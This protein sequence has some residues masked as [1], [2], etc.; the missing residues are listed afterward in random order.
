MGRREWVELDTFLL[1]GRPGPGIVPAGQTVT[2]TW[3]K[4]GLFW[5]SK[6]CDHIVKTIFSEQYCV[7]AKMVETDLGECVAYKVSRISVFAI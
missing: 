4:R 2:S 7:C 5:G 6:H 1:R 3:K